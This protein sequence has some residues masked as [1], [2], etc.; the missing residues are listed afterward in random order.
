MKTEVIEE[1]KPLHEGVQ[2]LHLDHHR[3]LPFRHGRRQAEASDGEWAYEGRR[4]L[5]F[6]GREKVSPKVK[7]N[8]PSSP[9]LSLL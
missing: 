7:G 9:L 3:G 6:F 4:K 5:R 2:G 8:S 1:Q